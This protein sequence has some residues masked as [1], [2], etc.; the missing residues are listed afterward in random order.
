MVT[1]RS[2][3]RTYYGGGPAAPSSTTH[4]DICTL[5]SGDRS[6]HTRPAAGRLSPQLLRWVLTQPCACVVHPPC[7]EAI[8]VP[9]LTTP[10]SKFD[11]LNAR[12]CSPTL[13]IVDIR[14]T[15]SSYSRPVINPAAAAAAAAA[16]NS[17]NTGTRTPPI[18]S[19][20]GLAEYAHSPAAVAQGSS[21]SGNFNSTVAAALNM[22][23]QP[24]P[25]Q[26]QQQKQPQLKSALK[27]PLG[28]CVH[29]HHCG[30]NA[31]LWPTIMPVASTGASHLGGAAAFGTAA[32][33]RSCYRWVHVIELLYLVILLVFFLLALALAALLLPARLNHFAYVPGLVRWVVSTIALFVMIARVICCAVLCG[34]CPVVLPGLAPRGSV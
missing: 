28:G 13:S 1:L 23:L 17:N 18:L 26:Q 5:L 14:T 10:P 9:Q 7:R 33:D 4:S 11:L 22:G 19:P 6:S 21:G 31:A 20:R 16:A 24:P 2:G 30:D 25:Q 34:L 27:L 29:S 8:G 12:W 32:D 3:W 15:P